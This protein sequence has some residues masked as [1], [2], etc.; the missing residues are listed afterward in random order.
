M[1]FFFCNAFTRELSQEVEISLKNSFSCLYVSLCVLFMY[2][3]NLFSTISH[4]FF[5]FVF[6]KLLPSFSNQHFHSYIWQE[7]MV[8]H[9]EISHSELCY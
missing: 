1:D 6:S 4:S 8:F 3:L 9:S 7:N 2:A 5:A